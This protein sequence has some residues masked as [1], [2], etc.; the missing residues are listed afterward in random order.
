ML[1]TKYRVGLVG[2]NRGSGLVQPFSVFPE[3]EIVALCDLDGGRLAGAA[4]HY[5]VPDGNLFTDY[6][7]FLN[8]P[9]DVVV[10]ST[11]I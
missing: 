4:E 8:A 3:T 5:R 11:P 6:E 1:M 10:I 2:A 7:D 9:I